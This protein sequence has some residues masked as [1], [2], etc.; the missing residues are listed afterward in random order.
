MLTTEEK[1]ALARVANQVV[2]SLAARE[3]ALCRDLQVLARAF[4]R[5]TSEDARPGLPPRPDIGP[6]LEPE[7]RAALAGA[8]DSDEPVLS[9]NTP[10]LPPAEP[11]PMVVAATAPGTAPPVA[12]PRPALQQTTEDPEI[13]LGSLLTDL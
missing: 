9:V 12:T 13:D 11:P 4:L 8:D 7:S 5:L 2:Q 10:N 6:G 3:P 1:D